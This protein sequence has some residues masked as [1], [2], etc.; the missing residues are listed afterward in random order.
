MS[1]WVSEG[2]KRQWWVTEPAHGRTWLLIARPFEPQCPSRVILWEAIH[3]LLPWAAVRSRGNN[4]GRHLECA[5]FY[6]PWCWCSWALAL[7]RRQALSFTWWYLPAHLQ[8]CSRKCNTTKKGQLPIAFAADVSSK[9]HDTVH[10][11]SHKQY[12]TEVKVLFDF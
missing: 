1:D 5:N 10:E 4:E 12:G 3:H 2:M 8:I 9:E 7:S 11:I 6:A